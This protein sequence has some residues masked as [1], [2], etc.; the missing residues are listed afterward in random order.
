MRSIVFIETR[1]TPTA[2]LDEELVGSSAFGLVAIATLDAWH[3]ETGDGTTLSCS[4]AE[5][6]ADGCAHTYAK[7]SVGQ[8]GRDTAGQPAY[9]VRSYGTWSIRY[10]DG[11][12]P[13]DIPGAPQTLDGPSTTIPVAVA[14]I[15]SVVSGGGR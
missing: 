2:D 15:Q 9:P 11:G 7:A 3:I 10:E 12:D 14:E 1:F 13:I 4:A 5:I 6:A 8:T